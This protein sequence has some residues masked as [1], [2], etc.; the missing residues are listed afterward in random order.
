M[1][2]GLAVIVNLG[3]AVVVAF[4]FC[5]WQRFQS[6]QNAASVRERF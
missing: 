4:A 5:A 6:P 3:A 1:H 2:W